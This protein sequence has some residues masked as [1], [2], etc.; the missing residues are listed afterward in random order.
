MRGGFQGPIRGTFLNHSVPGNQFNGIP[1]REPSELGKLY[2]SNFQNIPDWTKVGSAT[3]TPGGSGT[4]VSGGSGFTNY[5]YLPALANALNDWDIVLGFDVV[6][7]GIG[8]VGVGMQASLTGATVNR[9]F[10]G[11]WASNATDA[12]ATIHTCYEGTGTSFSQAATSGTVSPYSA[13]DRIEIAFN[14]AYNVYSL[15]CS[16]LNTSSVQSCN[17]TADNAN[18]LSANAAGYFAIW[19]IGGTYTLKYIRIKSA[20]KRGVFAVFIGDS[21]T[22]GLSSTAKTKKYAEVAMSGLG[23]QFEMCAG[24][25][26]R[27]SQY[28]IMST[29]IAAYEAEYVFSMIGG[30]DIRGSV[31]E[32]IWRQNL[33]NIRNNAVNNGKSNFVWLTYPPE[34]TLKFVD[35]NLKLRE[36]AAGFG[37]RLIDVAPIINTSTDIAVDNVHPNDLGHAKIGR[38][39]RA[40]MENCI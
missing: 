3:Y 37:D 33:I 11:R 9:T 27:T 8:G 7:P 18:T 4:Q 36:I 30:N 26:D 12:G 20:S 32:T 39:I 1:G 13:G 10:V 16:N 31:S 15:Q 6:T 23:K 21:K 40:A 2:F 34:V 5:I 38:F 19:A 24:P 17:Y 35:F 28:T 25:N 14:K 29:M 22:Y